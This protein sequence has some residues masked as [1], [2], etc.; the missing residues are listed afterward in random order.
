MSTVCDLFFVLCH[1]RHLF[2]E[3]QAAENLAVWWK[4]LP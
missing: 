2:E 4:I 3:T 1:L